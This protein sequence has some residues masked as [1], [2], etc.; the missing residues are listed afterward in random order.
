L[1]RNTLRI[2]VIEGVL[3]LKR[4]VLTLER[5]SVDINIAA[6]IHPGAA[7]RFQPPGA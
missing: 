1:K 7:W 6:T 4:M 5:A 2:L 3:R